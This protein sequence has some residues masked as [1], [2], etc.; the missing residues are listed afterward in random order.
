MGNAQVMRVHILFVPSWYVSEEAPLLG[1]FFREQAEAFASSGHRVGVLSASFHDMPSR[2]WFS[3][4]V[5]DVQQTTEGDLT[6][7]RAIE[8][9][10]HPG[11]LQ[12][13]PSIYRASVTQRQRL[14]KRMFEHYIENRGRPDVVHAQGSL[15]GGVIAHAIA[16]G[17][18]IPWVVT[19]HTSTFARGIVG[20]RERR[21]AAVIFQTTSVAAAVSNSLAE[22]LGQLLDLEVEFKILPNLID[23]E[24]FPLQPAADNSEFIW[25]SLSNLVADKGHETLLRAFAKMDEGRLQIAGDGPRH[26]SLVRLSGELGIADRVDFLGSIAREDVPTLFAGC[27]GFVHASRYETFGIVILEALASGRPVVC[28]RCGGPQDILDGSNGLFVDVD[29]VDM[30]AEA[31]QEASSR[32][33]EATALRAS[34]LERF[35]KE[36]FVNKHI[37]LYESIL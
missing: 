5:H 8:R 24:Q 20:P 26:S 21:T 31:M 3:S 37:A 36:E 32:K 7:L 25:L 14:G 6:V 29:D 17:Q 1:S 35:S 9:L 33:W 34:V 22:D 27:D 4:H 2:G 30:L 19:E 23:G 10:R 11:P 16:G 15:W 12:R 28:T 13:I 18:A